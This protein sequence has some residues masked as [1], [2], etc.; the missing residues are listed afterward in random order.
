MGDDGNTASL[1]PHTEALKERYHR[2]VANFVPKLKTWRLTLS[3]PFINRSEQVM[4]LVAGEQK[5][6]R[7]K[8]V[9]EGPREP[10]RLPIQLIEPASG[11]LLWIMDAG[12]AG[13]NAE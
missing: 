1:F 2:C 13:M 5:A 12:A 7:A 9:L 6:D 11:Q 3:A 4:V 10:E 8:E